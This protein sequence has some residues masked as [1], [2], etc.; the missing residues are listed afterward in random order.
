[1]FPV[2]GLAE[3]TLAV[4]FSE[5]GSEYTR[6]FLK[7]HSLRIGEPFESA[8]PEDAD[9]VGLVSV[10]TTV[11]GCEYRIAGAGDVPLKEGYVG[12]IQ[13]RGENV[14]LGLYEDPE[15]TAEMFTDDGWLRTGDCG[16]TVNG[17]LFITGRAKDIIIINGQNYYP[18]DLEGI[19]GKLDELELGRVVVC[20]ANRPGH[21]VEELLVFVLHRKDIESFT[22]LADRVRLVV[23]ESAGLHVDHVIPISRVPKTTSGKI[24]RAWLG[25]AYVDGAFDEVIAEQQRRREDVGELEESAILVDLIS[26]CREVWKASPIGPDDNLF[27]IGMTSLE[28]V[29]LFEVVDQKYPARADLDD[30]LDY[31]T[32]RD[33]SELL[34]ERG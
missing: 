26:L 2:Y 25:Q 33:F 14:S 16:V 17:D 5:L 32:L 34:E 3:A 28:M 20:G 13:L 1:M 12:H 11:D 9:A 22:E 15:G 31:P 19:V 30:L 23:G 27:E 7:R 4:T 21:Q 8:A 18:H 29:E 6:M 24:Q 10:G